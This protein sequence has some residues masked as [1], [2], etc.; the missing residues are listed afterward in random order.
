VVEC[1]RDKILTILTNLVKNSINFTEQGAIE[2]GCRKKDGFLE[3][4]VSDTG[5][6]ISSQDKDLIFNRFRQ[7]SE[8]L[9]RTHEG[10]GLGLSIAKGYVELLGGRIWF[11]SESGKGSTFYFTIPV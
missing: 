11:E 10:A 9:T 4:F 7:C 3:F 8:E 6:G 5:I 1:D 2:F